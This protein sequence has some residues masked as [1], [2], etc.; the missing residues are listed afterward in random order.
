MA[1]YT[2]EVQI[3]NSALIKLGLDTLSS[4]TETNKRAKYCS[5]M[6]PILRDEV[7]YSHPWNFAVVRSQIARTTETPEFGWDY[8]FALPSDCLRVLDVKDNEDGT[9]K[10]EIGHNQGTLNRVLW[11]DESTMEIK[12]IKK[13]TDVTQF[14]PA[15]GEALAMRMAADL[16]N[17]LVQNRATAELWMSAYMEFVAKARSYDAQ[18]GNF[19]RVITSTWKNARR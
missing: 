4:L 7:L 6:Y 11:S 16:A 19:Q 18:E 10:Y 15:F 5:K 3:C 9:L 17:P 14:T 12:Y 1:T 2:S 8:E 13:V